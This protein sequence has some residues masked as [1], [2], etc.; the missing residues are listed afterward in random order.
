MKLP[1]R[2]L[3]CLAF[4]SFAG[5]AAAYTAGELRGDCEAAETMLTGQTGDPYRTLRGTRCLAYVSGVV[6][7][8]GIGNYLADKVGVS[9]NA[10][11]LPAGDDHTLRLLRAVLAQLARQLPDSSAPTGA[12]TA[13]ALAKAFPCDGQ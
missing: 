6:D 11:C 5:P 13:A 8:Y 4:L 3:C 10:F 9:L 1:L 7:G 12:L 2:L